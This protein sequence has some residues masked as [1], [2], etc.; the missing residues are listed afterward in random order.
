MLFVIQKL[1]YSKK[2]ANTY[3]S[4]ET[5][6]ID[7]FTLDIDNREGCQWNGLNSYLLDEEYFPLFCVKLH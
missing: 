5:L 2:F 7:S 3:E 6:N 1:E 4:Y